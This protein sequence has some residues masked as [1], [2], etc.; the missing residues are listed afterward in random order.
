MSSITL[1]QLSNHQAATVTRIDAPA[2]TPE[3][4]DWLEE[5]GF[6]P[7]EQAMVMTRA[8]PGGDPLVVRVGS[9]TFALRRIEAA[10]VSVTRSTDI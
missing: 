7:G 10:C 3:W 8:L 2:N 4:H 1:D 6:I 9:S 5:I